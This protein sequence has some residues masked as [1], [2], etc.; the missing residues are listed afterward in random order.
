M[1][2]LQIRMTENELNK[3][4]KEAANDGL[5]VSEYVRK[6]LNKSRNKR[7]DTPLESLK[8]LILQ[9][10]VKRSADEARRIADNEALKGDL[11]T[12]FQQAKTTDVKTETVSN[13]V[14]S[15]KDDTKRVLAIQRSNLMMNDKLAEIVR[16]Y[17]PI[18]VK[19]ALEIRDNKNKK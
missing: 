16:T 2:T 7:A 6:T 14:K 3:L 13:F 9:I 1:A 11:K 8:E 15:I 10:E 17:Y 5:S 18:V 12:I 19:E 4:K